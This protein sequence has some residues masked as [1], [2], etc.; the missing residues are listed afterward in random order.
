MPARWA[1]RRR[2]RLGATGRSSTI[3]EIYRAPSALASGAHALWLLAWRGNDCDNVVSDM[4]I[5]D[6]SRLH[7]RTRVCR[8]ERLF[9]ERLGIASA[10]AC[11]GSCMELDRNDPSPP[12]Q[13]GMLSAGTPPQGGSASTTYPTSATGSDPSGTSTETTGGI[14]CSPDDLASCEPGFECSWGDRACHPSAGTLPVGSGCT[15]TDMSLWLDDCSPEL[16]CMFGDAAGRCMQT[17]TLDGSECAIGSTCVLFS[18][19]GPQ[20]LCF[21]PCSLLVQDCQRPTI[22]GCYPLVSDSNATVTGCMPT[23]KQGVAEQACVMQTECSPGFVCTDASV[24]SLGC[25]G[26]AVSCCSSLC[27]ATIGTCAGVDAVCESFGIDRET[28][29]GHCT[30]VP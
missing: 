28:Q 23:T 19:S 11:L 17:C 3:R 29:A 12:A 9:V 8:R 4:R 20:G 22:D 18:G 1:S 30:K 14:E 5:V 13:G 7:V 2:A 21:E 10:A 16:V 6:L 27:D 24:H 15:V 25:P 26:T